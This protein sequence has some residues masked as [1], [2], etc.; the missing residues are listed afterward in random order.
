MESIPSLSASL[1]DSLDKL[2]PQVL[3]NPRSDRYDELYKAGQRSVVDF[4]LQLLKEQEG[5]Y[6]TP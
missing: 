5:T 4:L 1:I 2:Y 6:E 3:P